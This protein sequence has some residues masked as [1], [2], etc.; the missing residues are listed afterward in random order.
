MSGN[1][2]ESNPPRLFRPD[3][4]F[5][6]QEAHQD[7]TIPA[8]RIIQTGFFFNLNV[9]RFVFISKTS[10]PHKN[11]IVTLLHAKFDM[12]HNLVFF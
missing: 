8:R 6:D 1:G 5:E 4:D 9:N 12:I 7:L 10:L 2:W 11:K 3:T